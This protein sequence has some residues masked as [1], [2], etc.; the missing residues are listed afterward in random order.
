MSIGKIKAAIV[1]NIASVSLAK[2]PTPVN[3]LPDN[4]SN[5]WVKR[6]DKTASLYGGNK[7]RKLELILADA[8]R[9][10]KSKLTTFGAIGTNHGVATA[11]YCQ[12]QSIDCTVLLFDQPVTGLV[13][14]NL[15]LMHGFGASLEYKGSLLKTALTFYARQTFNRDSYYLTAGGSNV[16]GCI[17]YVLAALELCEQIDAG[18]LPAPDTIVCPL[19]SGSTL[20]GLSL[21]CALA[22]M[23]TKVIGVRVAPQRLGP[24]PVCTEGEVRALIENTQQLLLKL[25]YGYSKIDSVAVNILHEYFGAGY[26]HASSEGEDAKAVFSEWGISVEATY[27]AKTAAAVLDLLERNPTKNILYWHT[28][29]SADMS[30]HVAAGFSSLPDNLK[31]LIQ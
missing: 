27:T 24:I 14:D 10:G 18:E 8:R 31:T 6:D 1:D 19:G 2:L 25:C 17:A 7:V 5:L 29:S 21:G 9:Q 23:K 15:A 16:Y 13:R 11:C 20:A 28:Y 12:Q 3:R 22:G 30:E 26:G 4:S